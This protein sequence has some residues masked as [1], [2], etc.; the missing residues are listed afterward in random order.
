MIGASVQRAEVVSP[1]ALSDGFSALPKTQRLKVDMMARGWVVVR[2][3]V[4]QLNDF[5][6]YYV[7]AKKEEYRVEFILVLLISV[8]LRRAIAGEMAYDWLD[9]NEGICHVQGRQDTTLTLT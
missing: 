3:L 6:I 2:P 4:M 9:F 1:E 7:V 5:I 8:S